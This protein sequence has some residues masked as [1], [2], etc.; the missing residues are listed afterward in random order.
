[1][2]SVPEPAGENA[3]AASPS[4][5]TRENTPQS[6]AGCCATMP[7]SNLRAQKTTPDVASRRSSTA[8]ALSARRQT[9]APSGSPR[10]SQRSFRGSR[11]RLRRTALPWSFRRRGCKKPGQRRRDGG[12]A[13]RQRWKPSSVSKV[14]KATA[15]RAAPLLPSSRRSCTAAD[16]FANASR[17]AAG[18]SSCSVGR[19][20][21]SRTSAAARDRSRARAA[22]A[23]AS[24]ARTSVRSLTMAKQTSAT[25]TGPGSMTGAWAPSTR[26]KWSPTNAAAAS[27]DA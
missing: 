5:T 18:S 7:C 12:Y 16:A 10:F 26:S 2:V 20:N 24:S 3:N 6:R 15:A 25:R 17:S 4:E 13:W 9:W 14:T 11:A 19:F 23:R 22:A 21:A 27:S 1:M 8:S